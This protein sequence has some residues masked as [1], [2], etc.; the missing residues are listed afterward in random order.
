MKQPTPAQ[1]LDAQPIPQA[2]QLDAKHGC[3]VESEPI[4][5]ANPRGNIEKAISFLSDFNAKLAD[6]EQMKPRPK[7]YALDGM[8][9]VMGMLNNT[10]AFRSNAAAARQKREVDQR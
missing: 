7:H 4:S 3:P 1:H 8:E 9:F 5:A 10:E 6:A 2:L